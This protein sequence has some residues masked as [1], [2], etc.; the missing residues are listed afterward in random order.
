[1]NCDFAHLTSVT[2]QLYRAQR[3]LI[4]IYLD[5]KNNRCEILYLHFRLIQESQCVIAFSI[6]KLNWTSLRMIFFSKWYI[7]LPK[8]QFAPANLFRITF[9]GGVCPNSI[10][11]WKHIS[12]LNI[13]STVSNFHKSPPFLPMLARITTTKPISH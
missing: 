6:L 9:S 7:T 11:R 4:R 12:Y 3:V 2:G 10:F 13:P 1:M 5:D 8:L